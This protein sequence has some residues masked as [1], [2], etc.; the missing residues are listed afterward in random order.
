MTN[1]AALLIF[2]FLCFIFGVPSVLAHKRG[3]WQQAG[4]V[5][6]GIGIIILLVIGFE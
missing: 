2:A 4:A 5:A 3:W 1:S 6:L